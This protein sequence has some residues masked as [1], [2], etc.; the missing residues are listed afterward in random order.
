MG[1]PR[2]E[3]G[4]QGGKATAA[5]GSSIQRSSWCGP[6]GAGT[7]GSMPAPSTPP[8]RARLQTP[9]ALRPMPL[10]RLPEPFDHPDWLSEVKHDGFRALAHVDGHHCTLVSRNGHTFKH[11]PQL[12]EELAH[13]VKAEPLSRAQQTFAR[14]RKRFRDRRPRQAANGHEAGRADPRSTG[15][16]LRSAVIESSLR[17]LSR[18]GVEVRALS[19]A[20]IQ[21][22]LGFSPGCREK[23]NGWLTGRR[24]SVDTLS[25]WA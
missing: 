23:A 14:F 3:E 19:S 21:F 2:Q 25:C 8:L 18:S 5:T 4:A 24:S 9:A 6:R 10:L 12:C 15:R 1:G 22:L 17:S 13:A 20:P 11:W 7:I 16:R